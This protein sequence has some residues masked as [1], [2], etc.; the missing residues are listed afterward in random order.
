MDTVTCNSCMA[1]RTVYIP[2]EFQLITVKE[3]KNGED[4]TK[5]IEKRQVCKPAYELLKR[6]FLVKIDKRNPILSL[7]PSLR[8][9]CVLRRIVHKLF[10]MIRCDFW[11]TLTNKNEF[12]DFS[13][14]LIREC[15]LPLALIYQ[16]VKLEKKLKSF[17]DQLKKH[18]TK[19]AACEY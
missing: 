10:D 16:P 19:C 6:Y 14:L 8:R 3:G 2:R 15:Y 5:K 9:L 1:P 7:N 11:E 12:R 18:I 17:Y 4:M 13:Y